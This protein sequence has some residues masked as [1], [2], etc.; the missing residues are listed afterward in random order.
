M[1]TA[2]FP[3]DPHLTGIAIAYTNSLYIADSVLPRVPVGKKAFKWLNLSLAETFSI[4]DTRVGRKGRPNE[5]ELSATEQAAVVEDYALDDP[6]PWDDINQ[7]PENYNPVERA[8]MQL[9]EYILMDREV[10]TANLVFNAAK[11]PTGNK[12]TLSG[13]SQW[14]DLDESDPVADILAGLDACLVR[15]NVAVFGQETW[16]V[17]RRHPKIVKAVHR[18]AGDS[19]VAGRQAVAELFELEEVLVGVGL[20]NTA[21][22]GQTPTLSRI[23][24]K[25]AALIYRNRLADTQGGLTFGYTAEYGTRISGAIEDKDIGFRGGQRVRVGE[26][27]KELIV[28]DRAG[29]LIQNAVQ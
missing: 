4:P 28:A 5:V 26:S 1:T 19:G 21:K 17:L 15:P 13:S 20:Y 6:I 29:Y 22:K 3:V 16:S 11:Y 2:P 14:S 18:N 27:V 8:T 23:W 24:G 10:R 9:T 7:A 12:V 25:H